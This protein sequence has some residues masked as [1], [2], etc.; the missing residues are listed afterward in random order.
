MCGLSD[1]KFALFGSLSHA[2]SRPLCLQGRHARNRGYNVII[3][4]QGPEPSG[5][6]VPRTHMTVLGPRVADVSAVADS[7]LMYLVQLALAVSGG[8]G[9]L[10]WLSE[11]GMAPSSRTFRALPFP[12][13]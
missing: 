10:W 13:H 2:A 4:T 8:G 3:Y 6:R 1:S 7:V 12:P 5:D 9:C 11:C